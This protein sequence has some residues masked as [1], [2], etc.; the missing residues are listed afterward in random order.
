MSVYCPHTS[1][2]NVAAG[3]NTWLAS[4]F[5]D[6]EAARAKGLGYVG[7]EFEDGVGG[8]GRVATFEQPMSMAEVVRRVKKHLRLEHG[9]YLIRKSDRLF[10]YL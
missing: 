5:Y 1:V 8:R 2:D 4:A 10:V 7:E 6:S 3:V 9:E